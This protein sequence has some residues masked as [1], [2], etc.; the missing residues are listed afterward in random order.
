MRFQEDRAAGW[1]VRVFHNMDPPL[2][3]PRPGHIDLGWC[4]R[5]VQRGTNESTG[6]LEGVTVHYYAGRKRTFRGAQ[7]DRLLRAVQEN[8]M[9]VPPYYSYR[10]V[11]ELLVRSHPRGSRKYSSEIHRPALP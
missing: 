1:G 8:R 5:V 3:G 10:G 2:P 4:S 7:A 6:G 9:D 11:A